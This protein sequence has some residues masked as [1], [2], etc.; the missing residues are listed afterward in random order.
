MKT[1]KKRWYL[2]LICLIAILAVWFMMNPKYRVGLFVD[3]HGDALEKQIF[4]ENPD[5][6]DSTR[7]TYSPIVPSYMGIRNFN[8]WEGEHDIIEFSL[9]ASGFGSETAYY[10]CYYSFDNVPVAFQNAPYDLVSFGDDWIWFG[11]GDNWGMTYRI[12]DNWFFYKACF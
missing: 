3:V 7:D 5:H 1:L 9:F 2:I 4:V 6:G 12:R 11:E 8:T 10:G